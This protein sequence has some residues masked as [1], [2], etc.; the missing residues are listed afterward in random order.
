MLLKSA[1]MLL[2]KMDA[3]RHPAGNITGGL[4]RLPVH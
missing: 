1:G 3:C 4:E 2:T